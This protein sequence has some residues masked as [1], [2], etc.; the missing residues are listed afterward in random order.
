MKE[1]QYSVFGVSHDTCSYS[2]LNSHCIGLNTLR[3][4]RLA[5]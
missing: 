2:Q 5:G 3:L 1:Y 4:I